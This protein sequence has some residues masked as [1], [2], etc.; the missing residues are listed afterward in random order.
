MAR[1]RRAPTV[2]AL[3]FAVTACIYS[4]C[5]GYSSTAGGPVLPTP[6]PT[7]G[8]APT[9]SPPDEFLSA[10]LKTPIAAA[11]LDQAKASVIAAYGAHPGADGFQLHYGPVGGGNTYYLNRSEGIDRSLSTCETGDPPAVAGPNSRLQNKAVGCARVAVLALVLSKAS[12][13]P[14]FLVVAQQMYN[15]IRANISN[16]TLDFDSYI[17]GQY[18]FYADTYHLH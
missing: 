9:L 12:G 16:R 8:P 1:V 6:S 4:A 17:R 2:A 14:E 11:S 3:L 10:F 15:Y 13:F 18:T 5:G 7:L